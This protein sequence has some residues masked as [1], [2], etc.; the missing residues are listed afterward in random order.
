MKPSRQKSWNQAYWAS[1]GSTRK[2]GEVTMMTQVMP[3]VEPQS[4]ACYER[5]KPCG[6]LAAVCGCEKSAPSAPKQSDT[7]QLEADIA[8]ARDFIAYCAKWADEYACSQPG[9]AAHYRRVAEGFTLKLRGLELQLANMKPCTRQPTLDEAKRNT[10]T[11]NQLLRNA[12]AAAERWRAARNEQERALPYGEWSKAMNEL[13]VFDRQQVV[14][15]VAEPSCVNQGK[16]ALEQRFDRA[17]EVYH[18]ACKGED[19]ALMR[20]TF[21]EWC[22]VGRELDVLRSKARTQ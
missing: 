5:A 7:A 3:G 17:R 1:Q 10:L 14:K 22:A 2:V 19:R 9:A 20:S 21:N 13:Y 15:S 6:H 18:L 4:L 8:H 12:D 11:R 16:L